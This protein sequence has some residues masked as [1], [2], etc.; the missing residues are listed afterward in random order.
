[1][2]ENASSVSRD[3]IGDYVTTDNQ[4]ERSDTRDWLARIPEHIGWYLSGFCDGES[5]F[6][7]SLRM[8]KDHTIGWQIVITFNVAQRDVTNLEL[9]KK[10]LGCGRLQ[11]RCDGV[12]YF[13]VTDYKLIW[14]R[15]IPFFEKF[16]LQ[17][18][19]KKVNFTLFKEIAS[20]MNRSEHLTN[21]GFRKIVDLREELNYGKGR[22]RK[23]SKLDVLVDQK[24]SET[25]RQ[26]LAI[27]TRSHTEKI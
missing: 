3:V 19:V 5:S 20:M 24:S 21:K 13:V 18:K 14:E 23:Y 7:A 6:N 22:T 15:V 10:H 12:H 17:S 25:I 26:T 8:R 1:M 4:Q 27:T 16:T 11:A 2:S 9:L